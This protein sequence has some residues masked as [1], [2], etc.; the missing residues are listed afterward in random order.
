[1]INSHL[2][3]GASLMLTSLSVVD[4]GFWDRFRAVGVTTFAA[5]PYAVDLLDR[6][7]FERMDLPSLRYVTQAG[8]RLAPERVRR[9]AEH[10]RRRGWELIVMYGQTEATARMAYLPPHL[11]LS[12][13]GSIGV[14]IPGGSFHLEALPEIPYEGSPPPSTAGTEVGELV[15]EGPNVML[16]YTLVG[17]TLL[18]ALPVM[19]KVERRWPFW[20]PMTLACLGLLTRYEVIGL[21]RG[22]VIHRAHIVF[23]LFALGWAA[24][25]T[26]ASWQRV[27]VSAVAVLTVSGFFDD[28]QREAFVVASMLALVWLRSI[29]VPSWAAR[30]IG[31][32]ASASLY[33]YLIHWQVYPHLEYQLPWLAALLSLLAGVALWRCVERVTV[34]VARHRPQAAGGTGPIS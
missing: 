11:A 27:L 4:P 18:M 22:D 34:Y 31:V 5:V 17:L 13:P 10:G 9:L 24:V 12:S 21:T 26:T 32:L 20:L 30:S 33:I 23:W 28:A 6:V 15:Y 3:A 7:G 8:G 16:G 25:R 14:P 19:D 2:L 1:V 29:R